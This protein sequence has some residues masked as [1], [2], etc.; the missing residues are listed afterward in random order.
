MLRPDRQAAHRERVT[1]AVE[2]GAGAVVVHDGLRDHA[3]TDMAEIG[4]II[5]H[6]D[7]NLAIV[8]SYA[9]A[10]PGRIV[11]KVWTC[12]IRLRASSGA[13]SG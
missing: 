11:D 10:R 2:T 8:G 1:D 5:R 7:K 9:G 3:E 13:R 6:C 12:G 4:E